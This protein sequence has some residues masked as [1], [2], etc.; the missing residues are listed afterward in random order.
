VDDTTA[1]MKRFREAGVVLSIDDFGTGYSSLGYLRQFPVDALKI[2]RSLISEMLA[3]RITRD[4]VDLIIVLG[5]K[6]KLKVIAEGIETMQQFELLREL[7]CDLGQGYLFSQPVVAE[8]AGQLLHHGLEM[9]KKS[10][11]QSESVFPYF[12]LA[13]GSR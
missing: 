7:G 10:R 8:A 2:D 6:L 13:R 11:G 3:D 9:H 4:T 1:C 5:H 12:L